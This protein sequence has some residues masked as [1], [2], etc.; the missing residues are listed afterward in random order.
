VT[1]DPYSRIY[2]RLMREYPSVWSSDAQLATYVRLLITAE[3][4]WPDRPSLPR[5][6]TR[7]VRALV[8][9]DL[10]RV[11]SDYTYRVRGLDA[12]RNRRRSAA[13]SAASRRWAVRPA[14]LDENETR[15]DETSNRREPNNGGEGAQVRSFMGYRLRKPKPGSHEGQHPD[16]IVC[17]PELVSRGGAESGHISASP[18]AAR[19]SEEPDP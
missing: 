1:D 2:H 6:L 18:Q 4:Y 15:Q 5:Y 7:A 14:M 16:C 17:H 11:E 3:K 19:S 10:I 8:D 12:E 13:S 9:A